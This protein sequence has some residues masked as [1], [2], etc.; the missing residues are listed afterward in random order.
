MQKDNYSTIIDFGS[1]E[2]RLGVFDDK[3]SKLFFQSKDISQKNNYEEY[4]KSINFLIREAENK[5]STHLENITVLY[6]TSKIFTIDLSIKKKL[7]QKTIFKDICSS[8]IL[9]ANQLIKDCYINK[10]IIHLIIKKYIIN[11]KEFL[12]IPNK[13][14]KLN[15]VILEIKFICLPYNQYKNVFETFKK[16]NLKVINFFSSSLVKSFKYIDFF[17][18]NKFVAFL[19]IGLDRTTI[20]FF[21]NQKLDCLNSIPIG[22]NHISKDISQIMKLSLDESEKLK[23]TFNKSEIDFSYSEADSSDNTDIIKKIIGK[24][25]SIDLLKK[26]VLTRVEEIIELSFKG[27]NI[28]KNI[29]KKQNLNLVLIGNGSKIFNRNSFQIEDKYNFKEINFYEENDIEICEAGLMFEENF[30]NENP[31]KLKKNQKTLG[32]FHRLFNIFGNG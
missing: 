15:S 13:I 26:V 30:K 6:D 18:E 11:D 16:N 10:K 9:E 29:D 7:D 5:I 25:I 22:G 4:L 2:L 28:S 1:S 24:N 32:F 19:D 23:K 8:I 14:P 12:N 20:I 31:Q 27:M 3:F 17:K 21:I